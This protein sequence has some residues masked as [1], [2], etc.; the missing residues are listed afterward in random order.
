MQGSNEASTHR[1]VGSMARDTVSRSLWDQGY[2]RNLGRS[3]SGTRAE[4][5]NS[6][7]RDAH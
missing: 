3:P 5:E 2:M 6:R 1:D 7:E 4:S